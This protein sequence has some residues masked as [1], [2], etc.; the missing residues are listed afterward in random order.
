MMSLLTVPYWQGVHV[1]QDLG[2]VVSEKLKIHFER[3]LLP[4]ALVPAGHAD[5]F[6]HTEIIIRVIHLISQISRF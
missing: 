1:T 2:C 6:L 3:N 4:H 5:S